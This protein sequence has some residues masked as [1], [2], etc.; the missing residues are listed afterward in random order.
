MAKIKYQIRSN[1]K[2]KLVPIYLYYQDS[3]NH[4]RIKTEFKVKQEYWN[5]TKEIIK[6]IYFDEYNFSIEQRNS[7]EQSLND[8]KSKV[9]REITLE[10]TKGSI[11]TR[12]CVSRIIDLFFNK[13]S[14]TEKETLNQ[15]IERFIREIKSGEHSC[16]KSRIVPG[17][18]EVIGSIPICSTFIIKGLQISKFVIPFFL[19][20]FCQKV[21]SA[22][23]SRSV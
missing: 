12:E 1:V 16:G 7:I 18:Q 9:E 4:F 2:G 8:L 22:E 19:P 20:V 17:S 21:G 11:I 14:E 23:N 10:T 6:P 3:N 13:V 15:Y 5:A